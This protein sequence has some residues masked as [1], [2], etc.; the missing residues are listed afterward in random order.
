MDSGL[1]HCMMLCLLGAGPVEAGVTQTPRHLIKTKGQK[2]TLKCSPM[3]GHNSVSWYQQ[4]LGQGP[5]FLFEYYR[6]EERAKGNFPSRF[7]AHQFRNYSSE[8]NVSSLALEDSALYLCASSLAQPCRVTDV[9]CANLCAPARKHLRPDM[10]RELGDCR[11]TGKWFFPGTVQL[12]PFE[13]FRIQ[14]KYGQSSSEDRSTSVGPVEA[15]VTQTPRHLIKTKGQKVTLRCSPISGH[16]SVSWYQQILGQGPQ[17]LFEYYR[18]EERAKGNFPSRF[19]AHQF[20]NYSSEM[21]VS[22]LALEDSA[23]YL[24][25]SSLAQ[26]CR[27]TDVL[28]A[29][30]CA[31]ARKH[32]RSDMLGEL[33]G[34]RST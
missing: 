28:C 33:G 29:N 1:L 7:S 24:C 34:C 10:Q 17:F 21:N 4:I 19:S 25:A 2:V 6:E 9:L 14:A 18:E 31:P 13:S 3:S 23:L 26:P 15:G 16:E 22:S 5:Q 32:L 12:C 20:R 11:G 27:G 8:M 30:L